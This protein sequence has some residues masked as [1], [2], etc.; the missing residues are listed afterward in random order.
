MRMRNRFFYF[1]AL[2]TKPCPWGGKKFG[3]CGNFKLKIY[4]LFTQK[5]KSTKCKKGQKL[6]AEKI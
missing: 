2:K 1:D 4:V 3:L 6:P 5:T